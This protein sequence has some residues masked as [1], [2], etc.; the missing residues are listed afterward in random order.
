MNQ[1]VNKFLLAG[2]KIMPEMHLRQHGFSYVLAD[3]QLKKERH[4][5]KKNRR[6]TYIYQNKLDKVCFQ[7]DMA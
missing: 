2:D 3:R 4:K 1:I 5:L 7:H 6:F